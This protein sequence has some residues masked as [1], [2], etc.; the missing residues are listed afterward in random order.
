[1]GALVRLALLAVPQAWHDEATTG[2]MGLA[3]LR[4]RFPIYFFGQPFMG[5]LGAYLAAPM[6]PLLGISFATLKLLP[7]LLS[8]VWTGLA[9]RLAWETAGARAALWT[10]VLL[11]V[12]P[13]FLL[14]WAHQARPQYPLALVLGTLALLVAHRA[15]SAPEPRARVLFLLLGLVL[16]LGFWTNFLVLVFFPAAIL[17]AARGG[18]GRLVRGALLMAPAFA[19]GSLPHWLYGLAHG[20][21]I[22]AAGHG[23]PVE[24]VLSHL[25][26]FRRVSW[27]VLVGVPQGLRATWAGAAMAVALAVAYGAALADALRGRPGRG[28]AGRWLGA[29]LVLLALTNVAVAVGTVYG[30][31]LDDHDQR[32]LLPVYAALVP[33]LGAWLAWQPARRAALLGGAVVLVHAGGAVTG[34]LTS[35]TPRVAA[36]QATRAEVARRVAAVLARDGPRRIYDPNPTRRLLTFLSGERVIFSD[37]YQEPLPEHALA[38]DGASWAGL[39]PGTAAFQASLAAAGVSFALRRFDRGGI[40]YVDFAV[41]DHRLVELDPVQLRVDGSEVPEATGRVLDRRADTLW[42]T[43]GPQRG[44]EWLRIDFGGPERVTLVRWI[45]GTFQ[46][47]PKGLRLDASLDGAAWRMLVELPEYVGPLYWSAG[48]PMQ[49][50]RAGRVELRVPPTLARYLRIT[51]TGS[52]RHRPWTV[53]ELFVYADAGEPA[54]PAPGPQGPELRRALREAGVTRLYADQGWASRAALADPGIR[55]PPANLF[56]D[57]YGLQGPI[58]DFLPRFHWGPGTGVLLE[59]ADVPGFT[60][61]ARRAGLEFRAR[62]LAGLDLFVHAPRPPPPDR[63]LQARALTVTA[64]RN[65]RRASRAVDGDPRTRWATRGPRSAG[66]WYRIDLT[67]PR[68]L[69]AVRLTSANPADLPQALR[70]EGSADGTTW[71]SVPAAVHVERTL[72]WGG[73][74]LLADAAAAVR[75]EVEPVVVRALRL[76][77][78]ESDPVFYWSIHDL[79]IHG[80]DVGVSDGGHHRTRG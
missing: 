71:W 13:D 23:V 67:V 75:L 61:A 6:Y 76:V 41:P 54:A 30:R 51:Q 34:S 46:E 8:I 7:V 77:L 38:V 15:A 24:A 12:P 58:A 33:L 79:E 28:V 39:E 4:G 80:D 22:P 49:R 69:R 59:A 65:P 21:A 45:P 52:D 72:R 57:A 10:A 44:G 50:V 47:V 11:A 17:L 36:V 68:R 2:L 18:V 5:A 66:D 42:T 20:T 74:A 43:A 19:V 37:P 9:A 40:L 55:V 73:I 1:V 64:S 53:R 27:P 26:A 62:R 31:A 60:L 35:F 48:R 16:G 3:V 78:T 63:P 70:V 25:D 32:Y 56:L 29:A 14:Y